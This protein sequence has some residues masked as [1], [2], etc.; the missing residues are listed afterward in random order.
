MCV[1]LF[2]NAFDNIVDIAWGANTN[3]KLLSNL[4]QSGMHA[5]IK[6][7]KLRVAGTTISVRLLISSPLMQEI[8]QIIII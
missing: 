1:S 2:L 4:T 3:A 5:D 6:Y 7:N 8:L